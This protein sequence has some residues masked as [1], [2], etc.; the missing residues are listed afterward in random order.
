MSVVLDGTVGIQRDRNGDVANVVW[1]LYGLPCDGGVPENVVFLNESFGA[2]SPQMV[3]FDLDDEEYVIY[4]DWDSSLEDRQA[5]E[6]RHFYQTYG[7]I[8]I[9]CL[10][11]KARMEDGLV[12]R[13]WIT[14]VKYY[15][16]YMA[17]VN[18]MADAG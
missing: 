4:A 5:R 8:L 15:E 14:P 7:Y 10:R 11:E 1:F 13:E 12:R 6:L 17:M 18:D 2:N 3:A 9:S 16:N